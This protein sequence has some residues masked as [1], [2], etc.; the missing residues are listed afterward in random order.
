ML[1]I[2]IW[3]L[4][5]NP[6]DSELKSE[7]FKYLGSLIDYYITDKYVLPYKLKHCSFDVVFRLTK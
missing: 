5:H 3:Y 7:N 4:I 1:Y 2:T 6:I